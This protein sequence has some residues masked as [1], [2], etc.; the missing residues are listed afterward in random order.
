[1]SPLPHV[2]RTADGTLVLHDPDAAGMVAAVECENLLAMCADRVQHFARRMVERGSDPRE[3]SILL[4]DVE[5]AHGG[6]LADLLMPGH[7]W[8]A[9]RDRGEHPVA[10]GLVPSRGMAPVVDAI[11]G[12]AAEALTCVDDGHAAVIVV[13]GGSCSVRSVRLP[14]TGGR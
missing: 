6:A 3:T 7:D 2:K 8:Q 10:V 13:A 12:G 9:Y 5:D 4:V 14:E 11:Q 1:M